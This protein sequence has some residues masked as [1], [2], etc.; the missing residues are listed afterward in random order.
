MT[1][2]TFTCMVEDCPNL[3]VDYPMETED[4]TAECG[5][6]GNTIQGIRDV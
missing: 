3:G 5:G 2:I 4:N 1:K 6:C